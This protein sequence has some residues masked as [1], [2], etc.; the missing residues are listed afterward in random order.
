MS[1]G[2][3]DDGDYESAAGSALRRPTP[4]PASRRN[5]T[6]RGR[7]SGLRGWMILA[8]IGLLTLAAASAALLT[9]G[10]ELPPAQLAEPASDETGL[11]KVVSG[12]SPD[13]Q[14]LAA[15]VAPAPPAAA[16]WVSPAP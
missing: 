3:P 2:Y 13:P 12:A 5:R 11:P 16:P 10:E 8:P 6:L 14:A 15:D 9:G 7:R 1:V 4:A